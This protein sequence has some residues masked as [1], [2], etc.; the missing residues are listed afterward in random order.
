M[1]RRRNSLRKIWSYALALAL[2]LGLLV[3]LR[4]IPT[5]LPEQVQGWA[6]V[7]DGDSLIINEMRIRLVG[8]D[9]P[10]GPQTCTKNGKSWR[11][12]VESARALRKL[13]GKRKVACESHG[14]DKHDRMLA[15]CTAGGAELN[16]WMVENGWAV[17]YSDYPAEERAAERAKRGIWSSKFDR[18]RSWRELHGELLGSSA[19]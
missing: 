11:C 9:A 16:R 3:I 10:E 1:A 5:S 2:A 6:K 14:T 15:V 7:I 18:P 8:I 17:S 19:D 13:I 12:G 4:H